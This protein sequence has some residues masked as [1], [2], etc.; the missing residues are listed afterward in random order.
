MCGA[1][2]RWTGFGL[3][4]PGRMWRSQIKPFL[5]ELRQVP[6]VE[7]HKHTQEE[8]ETGKLS[9]VTTSRP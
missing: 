7:L 9:F 2:T 6:E 8:R 1:K 4:Y 3:K 5:R